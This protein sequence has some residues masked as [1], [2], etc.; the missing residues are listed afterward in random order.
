[1][2][3]KLGTPIFG[4]SQSGPL[5]SGSG[6]KGSRGVA[7]GLQANLLH[8][9]SLTI[10]FTKS[11]PTANAGN[12][13][14]GATIAEIV[15]SIEGNDVRRRMTVID[16]SAITVRGKTI[17]VTVRDFTNS[18]SPLPYDVSIV[19]SLGVRAANKQPPFI[20]PLEFSIGGVTSIISGT[21][22]VPTGGTATVNVPEESGVISVYSTAI[23]AASASTIGQNEI[24]VNH[25]DAGA[26][27]QKS[28]NP[29]IFPD[30]VP[31]APYTTQ[32]QLIN[33]HPVDTVNFSLAFGIDG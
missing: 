21:I 3:P 30:W 32:I 19:A 28:Y 12:P 25:T 9:D 31:I 22:P 7:V 17:N 20:T 1:M 13:V 27:V 10:Q 33:L 29:I 4:W 6:P 14:T 23:S 2:N 5:R 26:V 11:G 8:E 24:R 15:S 18:A 16:G